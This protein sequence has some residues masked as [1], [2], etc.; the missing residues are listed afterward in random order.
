M[1]VLIADDEANVRAALRCVLEQDPNVTSV[2]EVSAVG[3]LPGEL[4]DTHPR[5]L[6]LDGELPGL[7]MGSLLPTLR[8]GDPQLVVIVLSGRPEHRQQAMAAGADAFVCKG[9][10]PDSLLSVLRQ[11]GFNAA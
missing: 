1:K 10:A 8:V 4:E 9:D 5:V 11:L 6:L 7:A 2:S 3:M